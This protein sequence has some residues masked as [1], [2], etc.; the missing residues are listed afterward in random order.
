MAPGPG[1]SSS[2]Q[3]LV[4]ITYGQ[5]KPFRLNHDLAAGVATSAVSARAVDAWFRITGLSRKK[6]LYSALAV[7]ASTRARAAARATT[8]SQ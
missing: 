7:T 6:H 4:F 5:N 3:N 8:S 2:P 1:Q